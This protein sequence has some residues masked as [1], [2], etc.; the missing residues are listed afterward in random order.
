MSLFTTVDIVQ[1]QKHALMALSNSLNLQYMNVLHK[2]HVHPYE[3]KKQL[4]GLMNKCNMLH[5][6]SVSGLEDYNLIFPKRWLMLIEFQNFAHYIRTPKHFSN[7][8][9]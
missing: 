6:L 5:H 2:I 4:L 9:L 3:L 1:Y 7:E 8:N